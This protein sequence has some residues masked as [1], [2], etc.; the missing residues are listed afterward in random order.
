MGLRA[1]TY[2][3]WEN[4]VPNPRP[5][6]F[7]GCM[8]PTTVGSKIT[9]NSGS[10]IDDVS[11]SVFESPLGHLFGHLDFSS[12][13]PTDFPL[14]VRVFYDRIEESARNREGNGS[15]LHVPDWTSPLKFTAPDANVGELIESRE[16]N[17]PNAAEGRAVPVWSIWTQN[18]RGQYDSFDPYSVLVEV[19][20]H[21]GT[22]LAR[23]RLIEAV[24]GT[25]N[26][27]ATMART[28]SGAESYV[29]GLGYLITADVL[30]TDGNAY[31]DVKVL[32]L[33]DRTL[34]DPAYPD[35]FWH[36][37]FFAGTV[38]VGR[39]S[40]VQELAQRLG[41]S[42]N[43]RVLRGGLWSIE[44]STENL[45]EQI[46]PQQNR[47]GNVRLTANQNPFLK[48]AILG[49]KRKL[50]LRTF[51]IW[52]VAS[53]TVFEMAIIVGSFYLLH[54]Q[55]R[56][57]RWLLIPLSAIIYTLAG[58]VV[59]HLVVDFRPE[60]QIFREVDTV[61]GWPESVVSTDVMR[62]GFKDERT[63]FTAP[64]QA[65]YGWSPVAL[66]STPRTSAPV[67]DR[68]AF[69]MRQRYG[70]FSNVQIQYAQL[71]EL[72]CQVTPDRQITATRP[73][74]GAW[75]WEGKAWRNLGPMEPG[76]PIAFDKAEV[77]I[78]ARDYREGGTEPITYQTG[79]DGSMPEPVLA[80]INTTYLKSL[81]GTNVGLFLAVD[82]RATPEEMA[83]AAVSEI[84]TQTLLVHQ[85]Q[86]P[87]SQP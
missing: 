75:L 27:N 28:N 29:K 56:V 50:E 87:A 16:V 62:L 41:L 20:S 8:A 26:R 21:D 77:V 36:N 82:D 63:S 81:L 72:P 54:G 55:R 40:E 53:F 83:D 38:V 84:H 79:S 58:L 59:V 37:V 31:E 67:E 42:P 4:A 61:E 80:L 60:V 25:A 23:K 12:Y 52:F 3:E 13:P 34:H 65:A 7:Q 46:N 35:S 9:Q 10:T 86:L 22:L 47:Y 78:G 44:H 33:D 51:S 11:S 64:Q 30:P 45:A 57:L 49:L 66:D 76:K 48:S 39:D 5:I 69:S 19:A 17:I 1:E 71:A 14:R 15:N 6:L 68:M 32:W 24:A 2:Q 70:R 73:L 85:F 18:S 74:H 43:Q